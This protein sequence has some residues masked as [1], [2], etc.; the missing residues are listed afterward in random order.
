[1]QSPKNLFRSPSGA[2]VW[3]KN[4]RGTR[5]PG[6]LP[7]SRHCP[8]NADVC[9]FYPEVGSFPI[10]ISVVAFSVTDAPIAV[11]IPSSPQSTLVTVSC[12]SGTV[13]L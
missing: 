12:F 11:E 3:S 13:F 5:A 9:F 10:S 6:P 4:K 1:M 2:S 8:R 7:W